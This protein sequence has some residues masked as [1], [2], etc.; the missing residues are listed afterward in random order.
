M[1]HSAERRLARADL[2][3]SRRRAVDTRGQLFGV[4]MTVC[5]LK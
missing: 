5:L 3:V 2:F 1:A 4:G